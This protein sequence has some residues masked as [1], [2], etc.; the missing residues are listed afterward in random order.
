MQSVVRIRDE[1]RANGGPAD[2][3]L[4]MT[5]VGELVQEQLSVAAIHRLY[6]ISPQSL[7]TA[8]IPFLRASD[9]GAVGPHT[10]CEMDS[11]GML[12]PRLHQTDLERI[13]HRRKL[14]LPVFA[15]SIAHA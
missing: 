3:E 12:V 6:D 8:L 10:I 4:T 1:V 15:H 11:R 9:A 13:S 7:L 2:A 5:Y 14:H